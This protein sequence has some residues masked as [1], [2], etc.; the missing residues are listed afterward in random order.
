MGSYR[1]GSTT[2]NDTDS[3]LQFDSQA[4]ATVQN[5]LAIMWWIPDELAKAPMIASQDQREA[6]MS[7]VIIPR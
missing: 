7:R 3:F 1:G 5:L 2:Y 6:H 4:E